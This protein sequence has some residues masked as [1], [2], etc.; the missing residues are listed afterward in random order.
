MP[1]KMHRFITVASLYRWKCL[2]K[3]AII[4]SYTILLVSPYNETSYGFY[5]TL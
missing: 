1:M 3:P 5:C 4:N 2:K